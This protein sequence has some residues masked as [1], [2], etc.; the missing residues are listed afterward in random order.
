MD[1]FVK[2]PYGGPGSGFYVSQLIDHMRHSGRDYIVQGQDHCTLE[3]HRKPQSLDVWLRKNCTHRKDTSQA[4]NSVM[5][6]LV[7][8]GRFEVTYGLICP[9]SGQRC[10]GLRLLA[11]SD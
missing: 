2:L 10:K 9:D 7:A 11:T 4:V 1:T 3:S 5:Y 6:A 8:T